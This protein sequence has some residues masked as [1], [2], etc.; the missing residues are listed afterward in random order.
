[1]DGDYFETINIRLARADGLVWLNLSRW[2]YMTRLIYRRIR[3][4]GRERYDLGVGLSEKL[5]FGHLRHAFA[6]PENK[7]PKMKQIITRAR[8]QNKAVYILNTAADA[9]RF[10]RNLPPR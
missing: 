7:G 8:A 5:N 3:Y 1:M 2:R 4:Y 6:Y 9:E 10:I